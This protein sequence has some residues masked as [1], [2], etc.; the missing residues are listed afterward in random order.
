MD[1]QHYM[2]AWFVGLIAAYLAARIEKKS[3]E[4]YFDRVHTGASYEWAH[5]LRDIP[6]RHARRSMNFAHA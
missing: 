1:F 6:G 3:I 5:T 2:I 4:T